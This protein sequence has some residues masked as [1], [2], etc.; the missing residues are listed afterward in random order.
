MFLHHPIIR[1]AKPGPGAYASEKIDLKQSPPEYSFGIRHSKWAPD[2]DMKDD[3]NRKHEEDA[4]SWHWLWLNL[5][6]AQI[7]LWGM[8]FE[9][10]IFNQFVLKFWSLLRYVFGARPLPGEPTRPLP[11]WNFS[12]NFSDLEQKIV[13]L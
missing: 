13:A 2:E 1:T 4:K 12:T 7:C 6:V 11:Y 8:P 10:N 9:F 5:Y 3:G